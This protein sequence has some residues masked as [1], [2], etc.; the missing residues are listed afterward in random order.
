MPT[1]AG[2]NIS[3][4]ENLVF[5][6]DLSDENS[7][8][9]EPTINLAT[10]SPTASGW[11][12]SFTVVD[13]ATKTFDFT[14]SS[15][16]WGGADAWTMFYYDVTEYTGQY[17]TISAIFEYPVPVSTGGTFSWLMIG[18]TVNTQTYLGYSG[19]L[20]RNQKTTKTREPISWSGVIGDGGKVGITIWMTASNP[21]EL[22][23][24]ISNIQVE[25]KSHKTP[26]INGTRSV[27]EGLVDLTGNNIIDTTNVSFDG[28][29][30]MVFDGT[31]DQIELL[32]PTE[33]IPGTSDFTI[34]M[35]IKSDT[36]A[37]M[38]Y[39]SG[40]NAGAG[41]GYYAIGSE[42]GYFI[43][44]MKTST[45]ARQES[46][47]FVA[48]NIGQKYHIIATRNSSGLKIYI[49]GILQTSNPDV[50]KFN[51]NET[52][53]RF[54]SEYGIR[55]YLDGSIY[56]YRHYDRFFNLSEIQNNYNNIKRK[57]GI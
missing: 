15:I 23:V 46:T 6:F 40:Y 2:P 8:V 36:T 17:V 22:T 44:D 18:Q 30:Q 37:R 35:V 13:S 20:D 55:Q 42:N 51:M 26:F 27:T 25:V 49:N 47:G 3:G 33:I 28:D 29:A 57:Y 19:A 52:T 11:P 32:N 16:P 43:Y 38:W 24:R 10:D 54:G 48:M 56:Y 12:G 39:V 50:G 31:D 21:K 9:G 41:P 14:T 45:G 4:E 34:E 1:S 53:I 7:Y 5:G